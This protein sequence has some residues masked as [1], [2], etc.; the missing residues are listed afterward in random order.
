MN[1]II[2]VHPQIKKIIQTLDLDLG[3]ELTQFEQSLNQDSVLI[4]DVISDIP[5]EKDF[6]PSYSSL[7][8]HPNT[9]ESEEPISVASRLLDSPSKLDQTSLL[10][11]ILTPWGIMAII[12]FF[13][14]N[15]FIFINQDKEIIVNQNNQ[16]P[17][18]INNINHQ[19]SDNNPNNVQE[20]SSSIPTKNNPPPLPISLP[21]VNNSTQLKNKSPYP[22]LKTALLNEITKNQILLPSPSLNDNSGLLPVTVKPPASNPS[23]PTP[24]KQ[25]KY[26][27]VT[28]YQNMDNFNSIKK[29][30][31]NALII[32]IEKDVKI[33]L[34][35]FTTETEAI[36][37]SQKLQTQ[38]IKTEIINY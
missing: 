21:D 35:I 32:N 19:A 34:G 11:L 37:Q 16:N 12:I 9:I 18:N 4:P 10:D 28:N 1:Q 25:I 29:V 20:L 3:S 7:V 23:T 8:Y 2:S 6:I 31:P 13:G 38:G 36:K 30:V 5:P 22:N 27:L 33:Q 24:S 26:S 15:L 17:Q 14:A